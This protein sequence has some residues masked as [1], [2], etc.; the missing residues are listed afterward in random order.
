MPIRLQQPHADGQISLED[1]RNIKFITV[2]SN[3]VMALV[4]GTVGM[5]VSFGWILLT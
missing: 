5:I 2:L 4:A 1:Y 3:L